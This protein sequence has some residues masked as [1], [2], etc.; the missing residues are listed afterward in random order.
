[1]ILFHIS[2]DVADDINSPYVFVVAAS[3]NLV[4]IACHTDTFKSILVCFISAGLILLPFDTLNIV[5]QSLFKSIER[6]AA[7]V[8]YL[9]IVG[10]SIESL[11]ITSNC[12]E[13]IIQPRW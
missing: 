13:G 11:H 4:E 3:C 7:L 10:T 5:L 2:D 12:S 6:V 1:M 9:L 8:I